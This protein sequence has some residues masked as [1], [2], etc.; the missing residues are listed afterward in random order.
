MSK[1]KDEGRKKGAASEMILG[2]KQAGDRGLMMEQKMIHSREKRSFSAQN[3]MPRAIPIQECT[4]APANAPL[5]TPPET[6]VG[7]ITMAKDISKT[8]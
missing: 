8:V 5:E 2:G 6:P 1:M 4:I 7:K 3:T